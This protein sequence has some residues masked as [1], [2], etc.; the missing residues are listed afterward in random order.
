VVGPFLRLTPTGVVV[1]VERDILL[2]GLETGVIDEEGGVPA[3]IVLPVV[4]EVAT[5]SVPVDI[6]SA[7][8]TADATLLASALVVMIDVEDGI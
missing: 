5:D 3:L 4:V 7:C 6:V 2:L 8:V 1:V